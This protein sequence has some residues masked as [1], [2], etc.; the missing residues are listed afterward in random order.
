VGTRPTGDNSA[1]T[2]G[3]VVGKLA[4]NRLNDAE[5]YSLPVDISAGV[6]GGDTDLCDV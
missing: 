4:P 1:I 2:S 3:I 5:D 6:L